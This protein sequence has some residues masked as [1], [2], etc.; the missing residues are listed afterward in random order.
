MLWLDTETYSEVR[1]Q[2]G[3]YIYAANC[4]VDIVSYAVDAGPAHV[5]DVASGAPMPDALAHWLLD[6]DT[7]VVSHN[8]MFDRNVLRLGNLKIDI[9][10]ERWRC[11]MVAALAH[12][13]PGSLDTLGEILGIRQDKRKLKIGRDLMMLFCKP[14]PQSSKLRRATSKTHPV[15]WTR[16]L[17]YAVNDVEAMR[18]ICDKL[19]NW[20]YP[21]HRDSPA[22]AAELDLWRLD[23][24][25][26]DR[27]FA[28]DIDL[29]NAAIRAVDR[30]QAIL[31]CQAHD[32]TDGCVQSATQRDRLMEHILMA[33][34][35]DLPD[36]K[37]S[38]LERRIYDPDLDEGLRELLRIRLQTCTTSTS[39][40]RALIYGV[41]ADSRLRG[42]LQF[43]GASRT[44]RSAGRTFQPQNLPSRG[45]LP[46]EEIAPGIDALLHDCEDMVFSDVMLLTS[47]TI[48]GTIVAPLRRKL[49]CSDLSNIEGRGLAW[50]AGEEWKLQAFRDFDAGIG[51]DLYK[52]AYSKSFGIG[53]EDVTKSQ[54]QIGKVQ[55]LALGYMGGINAFVTFAMAYGIDLDD[56]A[57]DAWGA[58]PEDARLEAESFLEWMAKT[59]KITYPLRHKTAVVC[60]CFKRLWRNAH[61]A[62]CKLATDLEVSAREAIDSPDKTLHAGRFRLRRTGAWLRILL[63]SGRSL[64]YPHPQV[65]DDG[66]ISYMGI[67]QYSRKWSRLKTFGGKLAENC[68]QSFARDILYDSM[69]NAENAGYS[70]VLHVHDELVTE[71]PDSAKFNAEGLSAIMATPPIY[72]LDMPLAAAGFESYRYRKG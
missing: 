22:A 38:T 67:D 37:A 62:T 21:V 59:K 33:Y 14:R 70:I 20:N 65:S 4:E 28:V 49:V 53:P 9:P 47:S 51:P 42:T 63:P 36:M 56:M 26:N 10:I 45:L 18:A 8:A 2:N 39:K 43:D 69:Q 46:P 57:D 44:R 27:G 5:W 55:E 68:T 11:S 7:T 17:E 1:I 6:T 12:G 72:A 52:L 58:L 48:R 25:I 35:V 31:A 50:L 61:P 23:Q 24:R 66:Q 41:S 3:T 29:A 71:T 34:G 13:L 15:E 60:D 40:Y 32:A 64:C 30:A 16:Y 19:P 54:R